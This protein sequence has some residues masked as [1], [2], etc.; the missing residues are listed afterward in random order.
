[1]DFDTPSPS[2]ANE[3]LCLILSKKVEGGNEI[4][5]YLSLIIEIRRIA[6]DDYLQLERR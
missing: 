4:W 3:Q 6:D 5:Q 2:D 1:M